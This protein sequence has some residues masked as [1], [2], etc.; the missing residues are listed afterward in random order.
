MASFPPAEAQ[1]VALFM[2]CIAYGIYLVTLWLAVQVLFWDQTGR[3]REVH[4]PVTITACLMATIST[5]DVALGLKHNMDAF[6]FYKGPGGPDQEFEDISY[7]TADSLCMTLIGDGMLIYR[8]WI[9]YAYSWK[10]IV[11]PLMM[12]TVDLGLAIVH[13]WVTSTLRQSAVLSTEPL[14]KP[15]FYSF[16]SLTI[17]I[18]FLTTGLIVRQI[19]L[20]NKRSAPLIPHTIRRDR[21]GRVPRTRLETVMRIILESGMIYTSTAF[22]TFISAIAGS[23]AVYGISDLLNMAVGISFNLIIIRVDKARYESTVGEITVSEGGPVYATP[24]TYDLQLMRSAASGEPTQRAL[25]ISIARNVTSRSD[26][27]GEDIN[28]KEDGKLEWNEPA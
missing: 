21:F 4:W 13:I 18:N 24:A 14:L 10:L 9:I 7:W 27:I 16:L 8:C 17:T 20:T 12:W 28:M 11:V 22:A 3:R 5:L 2:E 25:E 19:W 26:T 15:F 6:L 1:M 23:N